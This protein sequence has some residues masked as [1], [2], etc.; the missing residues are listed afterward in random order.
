MATIDEAITLLKTKSISKPRI[1]PAPSIEQII[2]AE[3]LLGFKFPPSFLTFL[4]QAGSYKLRYWETYWVGPCDGQD[5]VQSNFYERQETDSPLPMFLISFF[6]NGMGDQECFDTR[7]KDE[8]GEYPIVFWDHEKSQK[9]NLDQLETIAS[10][11]AE[12]L[13]NE[14]EELTE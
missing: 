4:S 11:F 5:I 2:S 9:E 8:N 12:W 1:F 3:N 14:V 13:L 7:C 6:N 10:N